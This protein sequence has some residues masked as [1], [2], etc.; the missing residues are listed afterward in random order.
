MPYDRPCAGG[1]I[2]VL[3]KV[4][5]DPGGWE[6]E[7]SNFLSEEEEISI[8]KH[9]TGFGSLVLLF[10]VALVTYVL[11]IGPAACLHEKT[12]SPRLKAGLETIYAPVIFLIEKTPLKQPGEWWVSK[13]IDLP[14]PK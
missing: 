4:G 12:S 10:C 1:A 13:W 2:I 14:G 3:V 9:E 8:K 5:C 7:R 6:L 11:S